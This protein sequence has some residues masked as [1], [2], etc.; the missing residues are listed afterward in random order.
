MTKLEKLAEQITSGKKLPLPR[1]PEQIAATA[2]TGQKPVPPPRGAESVLK[3]ERD[4]HIDQHN[5]DEARKTE[6]PAGIIADPKKDGI[7]PILQVQN[8]KPPT[9]EQQAKI[10]A[11]KAAAK[12]TADAKTARQQEL[13][14][15]QAKLKAEKARVRIE[16][17][18]AKKN[19][20][21]QAMPLTGTAALKAIADAAIGNGHKI[22]K[23][24]AGIRG[25]DLAKGS[26]KAKKPTSK[27]PKGSKKA[28]TGGKGTKLALIV[29][30]LKRKQ[31]CTTADVLKATDWPS[32]SMPQQAKAAGL[33]LRKEKEK[34][35]PTRYYAG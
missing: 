18:K 7:P 4:A 2:K 20:A 19:G 21:A 35:K 27:A 3:A 26:A 9:P 32:V 13:C 24:P 31:G 8:R 23:V 16:K 34:G 30:L 14:A 12:T 5:A 25:A 22:K 1:K 15:E 6:T 11:A 10:N 33:K 17:L 28:S 29:D